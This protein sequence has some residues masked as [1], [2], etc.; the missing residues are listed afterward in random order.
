DHVVGGIL[1][2]EAARTLVGVAPAQ[3]ELRRRAGV[4]RGDGLGG[5]RPATF[6]GRIVDGAQD[7]A[8]TSEVL[9]RVVVAQ[10]VGVDVLAAAVV[11]D[12][13]AVARGRQPA[14]TRVV[15]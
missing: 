14:R 8:G 12:Q 3:R 11:G 2:V 13:S 4:G 1:A 15:V 10:E 7:R 6:D 9:L 5:L